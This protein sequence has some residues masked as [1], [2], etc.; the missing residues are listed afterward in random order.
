MATATCTVL[1]P[2]RPS[3]TPAKPR[4]LVDLLTNPDTHVR[5]YPSSFTNRRP[6][7]IRGSMIQTLFRSVSGLSRPAPVFPRFP[8]RSARLSLD[9]R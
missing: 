9:K 7:R 2:A 4:R 8:K 3:R 1:Y 5:N 6:Y